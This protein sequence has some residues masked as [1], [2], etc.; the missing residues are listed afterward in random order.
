[1]LYQV[2]MKRYIKYLMLFYRTTIFALTKWQFILRRR[3]LNYAGYRAILWK[4]RSTMSSLYNV[5]KQVPFNPVQNCAKP[6]YIAE[7]WYLIAILMVLP[8]N[9]S[10]T[11]RPW[12]KE[13]QLLLPYSVSD[14]YLGQQYIASMGDPLAARNI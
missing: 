13:G 2:N 12:V 7:L 8:R 4:K 11:I 1:M 3:G 9:T 5:D 10:A 14:L 6:H